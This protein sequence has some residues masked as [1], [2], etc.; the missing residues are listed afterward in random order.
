MDGLG[1]LVFVEREGRPLREELVIICVYLSV[2]VFVCLFVFRAD[3][4]YPLS[5]I[6][7]MG[8]AFVTI[9]AIVSSLSRVSD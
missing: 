7:A 1:S 5:A 2:C 6:A 3:R 4:C 9:D 8:F